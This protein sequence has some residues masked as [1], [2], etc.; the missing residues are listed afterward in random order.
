[1]SVSE[2]VSDK[3]NKLQ[4]VLNLIWIKILWVLTPLIFLSRYFIRFLKLTL[5]RVI[6]GGSCVIAIMT[7]FGLLFNRHPL[8]EEGFNY[9]LKQVLSLLDKISW[10]IVTLV[11]VL[12]FKSQIQTV[13]LRLKEVNSL[14]VSDKLSLKIEQTSVEIEQLDQIPDD[15]LLLEEEKEL[16]EKAFDRAEEQ[17]PYLKED[18]GFL[19]NME[20][21]TSRQHELALNFI[22]RQPALS[23]K[24]E[25]KKYLMF[26][27][28]L[29][30][31]ESM[32][33]Y[34][35][36]K[37][38]HD[39]DAWNAVYELILNLTYS[40][41]SST[42]KEPDKAIYDFCNKYNLGYKWSKTLTNLK[43]DTILIAENMST[44]YEA[45]KAKSDV[46]INSFN[47]YHQLKNILLYNDSDKQKD[48]INFNKEKA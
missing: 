44:D 32:D 6:L 36:N 2:E 48:Q 5:V 30:N 21:M 19:K 12:I 27:H 26:Q 45:M 35:N 25:L 9:S 22:A 3:E 17:F 43:N 37:I 16:R 39:M 18:S 8:A 46:L 29:L 10:P 47:I 1:M 4:S 38:K 15:I 34:A 42:R 13:I 41:E 11:I 28:G 14:T 20:N 7:F 40:L 31:A 23:N 33:F 24:T